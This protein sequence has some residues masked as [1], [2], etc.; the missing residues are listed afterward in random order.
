MPR[1]VR[2]KPLWERVKTLLNPLD[3]LIWLSEEI[4]TR[5]WNSKIVGTQIGLGMNFAFLLA[6][7]NSGRSSAADDIFRDSESSGLLTFAV[8][9]STKRQVVAGSDR[10]Y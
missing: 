8:S 9:M 1:L 7:A 3:F 2:R 6:R 4:E 10:A 5:E